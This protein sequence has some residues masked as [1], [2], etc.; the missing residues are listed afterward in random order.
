MLNI[1]EIKYARSRNSHSDAI[2]NFQFIFQQEITMWKGYIKWE[3]SLQI[4]WEW[5]FQCKGQISKWQEKKPCQTKTL[6]Q[7]GLQNGHCKTLLSP[8]RKVSGFPSLPMLAKGPQGE[9]CPFESGIASVPA[10]CGW[11]TG[12]SLGGCQEEHLGPVFSDLHSSTRFRGLHLLTVV[13]V[14]AITPLVRSAIA[15]M[16]TT[17]HLDQMGN[18][19]LAVLYLFVWEPTPNVNSAVTVF[20]PDSHMAA[21]MAIANASGLR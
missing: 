9:Q 13:C 5:C 7:P 17:D 3:W 11:V 15:K 2:L 21:D 16:L 10:L 14:A 19:C 20:P 4:L 8:P 12:L 6:M 18:L 1:Y